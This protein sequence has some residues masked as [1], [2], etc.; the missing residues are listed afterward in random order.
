MTSILS[1]IF[2]NVVVVIIVLSVMVF[3]HELG[4]F[5]A[6]KYFGIRVLTFSIGFGKRLLGFRKGETDYRISLLPLGGYVKMA[7]ENPG[8]EAS[9]FGDEFS[10]KPRWQRFIVVLMG[11]VMNGVLAVVLLAVLYQF[12]FEK[13]TFQEQLARVGDVELDAPAA[14]AGIQAGD[15]IIKAEDLENPK[16]GDMEIKILTTV[17]EPIPLT[18]ERGGKILHLSVTPEPS[19]PNRVGDVGWFPYMPAVLDSVSEGLPASEAGLEPQDEIVAVNGRRIYCWVRLSPLL[20]ELEG[21]PL[22]LSVRRKESEFETTFKPEYSGLGGE[23][24]WRIGVIFRNNTVI[25]QLPWRQAWRRSVED[26]IRY[27][28]LTFDVLGKML[29]QRLS[30]RSLTGPVGI[31]QI[32]GQAYRAGLP[33]LLTLAAFISLQ[34]GIF[35]ILPI[36]IL[37]GG[38]I[39]FLAVESLMRRD[40]SVQLKE[41]FTMA[42]LFFLL[43]FAGFVMYNDILKALGSG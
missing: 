16:W 7:G 5:L 36:P 18:V 38:M 15:K 31:A 28:R 6:A 29:T 3:I 32:S 22:T 35:N 17:N 30:P 19:G 21:A 20:Q 37:D 40:M 2:E 1:A 41:R 43:L 42:G 23:M 10:S 4:H 33:Q 8:D 9:G 34:L 39:L 25:R 24:K 12:H 13:P 14:R 11:P 26:N 27:A